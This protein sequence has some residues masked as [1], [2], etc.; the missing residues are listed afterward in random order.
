MLKLFDENMNAKMYNEILSDFLLPFVA[1]NYDLDFVLH[2]DND[3][4]HKSLECQSFLEK[5][6]IKW[7]KK[8]FRIRIQ[9]TNLN[10]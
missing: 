8:P 1:V 10:L 2:Q 6:S 4:K 9:S 7:V 3:P 5:N